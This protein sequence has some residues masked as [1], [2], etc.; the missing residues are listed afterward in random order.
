M[1]T[2]CCCF[3][4]VRGTAGG[5]PLR[6]VASTAPDSNKRVS[7]TLDEEDEDDEDMMDDSPTTDRQQIRQRQESSSSTPTEPARPT[8]KLAS[9]LSYIKNWNPRPVGGAS[10]GGM[11]NSTPK[12]VANGGSSAMRT[13]LELHPSPNASNPRPLATTESFHP[14]DYVRYP[15]PKHQQST[16]T[17]GFGSSNRYLDTSPLSASS[18]SSSSSPSL[19]ENTPRDPFASLSSKFVVRAVRI[20]A[21]LCCP[22][23][24]CRAI[25]VR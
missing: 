12:P 13:S 21:A 15:S 4:F 5:P 25:S 2:R 8:K 6:V 24:V 19:I 11:A 18:V 1:Q 23:S 3:C 16:T 20:R 14:Q 17:E 9:D 10:G 22:W 7:E